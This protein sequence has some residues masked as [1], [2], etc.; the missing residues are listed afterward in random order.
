V[1]GEDPFRDFFHEVK[2]IRM[3]EPLAGTLGA[4]DREDAVLE[5]T[6]IETV[7]AAG[8]ACPTVTGAFLCCQAALDTIYPDAVPE[9]GNIAITVYGEP[10]EGALGVMAQVFTFITGAAPETGFKG[11]G[12]RFKRKDLLRF[13]PDESGDEAASFH[14]ERLDTGNAVV[15]KFHPWLIPYP[16]EKAKQLARLMQLVVMGAADADECRE[17]QNLWTD[18]IRAMV[19]EHEEIDNWLKVEAA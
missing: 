1:P 18:K 6:F 2:P 4:F 16:E 14:F 3:K 13:K 8:H 5:Y 19:I 7:K 11:L 9:R 12:P 17:F 15:V 10:G